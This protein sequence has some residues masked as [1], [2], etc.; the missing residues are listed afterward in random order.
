MNDTNDISLVINRKM[1][2][3]GAK[4]CSKMRNREKQSKIHLELNG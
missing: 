1:L 4:K 2:I 3:E